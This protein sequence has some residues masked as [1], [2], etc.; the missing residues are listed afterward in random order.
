MTRSE[1]VH[2]TARLGG[3]L[4]TALIVQAGGATGTA[5]GV[6]TREEACE[7]MCAMGVDECPSNFHKA[8][9]ANPGD[10]PNA[11]PGPNNNGTHEECFSISCGDSHPC[12]PII[13]G[14]I[15]QAPE[16]RSH[17]HQ[18]TLTMSRMFRFCQRA[19]C[20]CSKAR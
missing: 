12:S 3:V 13:G 5:K 14:L 20:A 16:W 11:G 15:E 6:V 8:W 17:R 7:F 10:N 19:A 1:K 9:D 4:V 18:A 2:W